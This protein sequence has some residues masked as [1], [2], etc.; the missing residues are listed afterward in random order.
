MAPVHT[1]SRPGMVA[2][3]VVPVPA[4]RPPRRAR[5]RR[6]GTAAHS[7][8]PPVSVCHMGGGVRCS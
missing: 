6:K 1:P 2:A 3:Y 7:R 8:G 5:V 4:V